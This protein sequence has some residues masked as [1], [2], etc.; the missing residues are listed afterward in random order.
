MRSFGWLFR[1]R[2]TGDLVL[3]QPPNAAAAISSAA[4]AVQWLFPDGDTGR[5][6]G[7]VFRVSLTW[8]AADELLR[9]VTP[10][11]RLLGAATL[12]VLLRGVLR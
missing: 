1:S 10:A 6:A 9:G 5:V 12:L 8:W 2:Q 3:G 7:I 4:T 11:R